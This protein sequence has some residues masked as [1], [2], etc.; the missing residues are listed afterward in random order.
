MFPNEKPQPD[1]SLPVNDV[2]G[3]MSTEPVATAPEYWPPFWDNKKGALKFKKEGKPK[4]AKAP[5][6]KRSRGKKS[7][8]KPK[9]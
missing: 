6:A 7:K 4:V 2:S 5:K 8:P 1:P 9:V 3:A